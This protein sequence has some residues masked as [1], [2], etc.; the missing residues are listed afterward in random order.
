VET[1]RTAILAHSRAGHRIRVV[2][3]WDAGLRDV[4]GSGSSW[5]PT[6]PQPPQ[7]IQAAEIVAIGRPDQP[8]DVLAVIGSFTA[9]WVN[10]A[11]VEPRLWIL[12][13]TGALAC[14]RTVA[15]SLT[16]ISAVRWRA[17]NETQPRVAIAGRVH[18]SSVGLQTIG[19]DNGVVAWQSD[20]LALE[21]GLPVP[22][23]ALGYASYSIAAFPDPESSEPLLAAIGARSRCAS[24]NSLTA[25]RWP[26]APGTRAAF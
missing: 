23:I 26:A 9:D 13:R 25:S 19:I 8:Q 14:E 16:P 1:T 22:Q 11:P 2:D 3:L 4:G 6:A 18:A 21:N 7:Q 12:D 24:T 5:L 15:S 17:A 20:L 10:C